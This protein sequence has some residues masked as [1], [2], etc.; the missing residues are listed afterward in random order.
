M[1]EHEESAVAAEDGAAALGTVQHAKASG[2]ATVTQAGRDYVEQQYVRGWQFLRGVSVDDHEMNLVENAFVDVPGVHGTGQVERAVTK[3][4]RPHGRVHALVLVGEAGTGRRTAA[5]KVLRGAGVPRERIRW[6]VLDWDQPRTEQIPHATGHGYVLDLASSPA[7]PEDFYTGLADY[8][9]KAE[10][11][12]TFLIILAAPGAWDPGA[13]ATVPSARLVRPPA[14]EIAE[15]H[16]RHLVPGRLD[17]LTTAPLDE[18][19]SKT[20]QPSEAARLAR[21]VVRA[22]KDDRKAISDEFSDWKQHLQDWFARLS[23]SDDL[24]ERALL[25]AA[26]LLEDVPASVVL[27]AADQ[28]FAEVGGA[29]PT[30][31]AL[32]GRDLDKRLEA[33]D[34][35]IV[36]EENISLNAERHGLAG[37]VLRYVWKQ[38]PQLRR[39][40]LEWA[41]RISAPNGIAVRHLGR[42]AT[43]LAQLSLLPG[44][45]TVLSVAS[46]WIDTGRSA[47]RQLAVEILETMALDPVAGPGVRKQLYDWAHQKSTSEALAT[48]V[49]EICSGRLGEVYPQIALTRLRL[50]A[51]RSD[52]R[53]REAV[54][55][56]V[57]SLAGAAEQRALVLSEIV[58]WA[59]SRECSM[60]QAGTRT[61]L[62]LTDIDSDVLLPMPVTPEEVESSS[63]PLPDQLFIRGWR[64]ALG[65]PATAGL[66]HDHLAAWLDSLKLDDDQVLP[67]AAAVLRGH[68]GHEGA[69]TLLVGSASSSDVGRSRRRLLLDQLISEQTAFIDEPGAAGPAETR[70][71]SV[72]TSG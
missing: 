45:S 66:A 71:D 42:I 2:H 70:T 11:Y 61:F 16:L 55:D 57:R 6:L 9:K 20:A 50:L 64:A 49:A 46:D 63:V 7:L 14:R 53:G 23:T 3:L 4:T 12:G 47:H 58:V 30:G 34:A 40:L 37:A 41:S 60:R 27:N 28:L 52:G 43:S 33:I 36:G 26:A 24:H 18:V 31:K 72:L 10:E 39:G 8:Q 54:A 5:L 22:T 19:L 48:A 69:A 44:G 35:S 29:L 32:A 38:R 17:W 56:A 21:L 62:A 25:I 51:S 13:F 1:T 67:L 68:L 59:E 65:E 15:A